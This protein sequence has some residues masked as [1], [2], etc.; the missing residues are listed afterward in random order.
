MRM[1]FGRYRGEMLTEVP[2]GYLAWVLE[3]TDV[4]PLLADAIR[5]EIAE[6]LRLAPR[7]VT[8]PVSAPPPAAIHGAVRDLLRA[9][10]RTLAPERHPDRGG[11]NDGMRRLLEARQWLESVVG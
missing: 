4:R 1:P 9:G 10:F 11:T 3:A 7:V 5:E 6:R 8:V 2:L